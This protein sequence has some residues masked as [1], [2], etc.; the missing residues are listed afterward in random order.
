LADG[1]WEV[2]NGNA[3]A[4]VEVHF[5][6]LGWVSFEPTPRSDG[7]VLVTSA[8]TVVPTRTQAQAE[9]RAPDVNDPILP[10]QPGSLGRTPSRSLPE[11][12]L[13]ALGQ[14][15][16]LGQDSG[17]GIVPW[18]VAA[19]LLAGLSIGGTVLVR[20]SSAPKLTAPPAERIYAARQRVQRTG[21]AVGRPRRPAETD[22][23]YFVRIAEG[24]TAGR[25]L[26]APATRAVYAPSVDDAE[27][28]VAERSADALIHGLTHHLPRWRRAVVALRVA[29]GR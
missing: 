24:N 6:E 18:L 20:R 4:W 26:A 14:R 15:D 5:A 16:T 1:R 19:V 17:P 11:E 12:G 27:A 28:H 29:V 7:N 9:G 2:T 23:E 3:H 13:L 25:A 21:A 10:D 8:E 22:I